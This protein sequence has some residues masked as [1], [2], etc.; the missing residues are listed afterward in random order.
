MDDELRTNMAK[1]A[2]LCKN[3][4]RI[5]SSADAR[6]LANRLIGYEE[7]LTTKMIEHKYNAERLKGK[8]STLK[9]Y[10]RIA[11]MHAIELADMEKRV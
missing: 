5:Q 9:E 11:K 7:L 8:I 1:D 10:M 3:M 4:A 2:D 6:Y